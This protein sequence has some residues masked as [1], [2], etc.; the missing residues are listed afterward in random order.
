MEG[1]SHKTMKLP[2]AEQRGIL[3]IFLVTLAPRG[4]EFNPLRLYRI[5]GK[6]RYWV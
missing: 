6:G 1:F 4:G 5:W 3:K 2:A